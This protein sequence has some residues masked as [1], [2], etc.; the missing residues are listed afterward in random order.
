V[1]IKAK[2]EVQDCDIWNFDETGFMMRVISSSI[3][4]IQADRKGRHKRVQLGNKE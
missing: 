3:V 1:N 4:V 2:Y